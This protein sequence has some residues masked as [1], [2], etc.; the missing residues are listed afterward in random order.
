MSQAWSHH[1]RCERLGRF[2]SALANATRMRIFC[3]IQDGPR[4]VSQI[5]VQ[6][7]ITLPNASQHLRVMR[8]VGVVKTRRAGRNVYY[9]IADKR[10]VQAANLAADALE[11]ATSQAAQCRAVRIKKRSAITA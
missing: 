3:S 8:Q 4:Q 1:Q 11:I 7:G 6:T 5:A 9:Y 10:F 2:F